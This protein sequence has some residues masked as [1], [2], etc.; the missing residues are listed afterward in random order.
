[1]DTR[2]SETSSKSQPGIRSLAKQQTMHRIITVARQM[3]AEQGYDRTTVRHIA[4]K[5]GLSSG[6]LFNHVTDKRDII[7]L[8]FSEEVEAVTA[9]ALEAPRTYQTFKEKILSITEQHF[10][11]FGGDPVL[12]RI[13]LN[14]LLIESPGLHLERNLT[15]RDRF[16][17]GLG[18]VVREAQET[19]EVRLDESPDVIALHIFFTYAAAL[20]RWLTASFRPDWRQGHRE[21]E[22]FLRL[23]IEG[24]NPAI[25][26]EQSAMDLNSFSVPNCRTQLGDTHLSV[27]TTRSH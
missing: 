27:K 23:Q 5:A 26:I 16:V 15:I 12:Y 20:R 22:R 9:R 11:F 10:R 25:N 3:F 4:A 7:H 8:I 13:L 19:G 18:R 24:L 2:R 1:M 21:F 6:A 14:E 17:Q